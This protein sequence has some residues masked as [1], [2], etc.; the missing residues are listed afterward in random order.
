M[1]DKKDD[2]TKPAETPKDATPAEVVADDVVEL[3]EG[4]RILL[5][6]LRDMPDHKLTKAER[7]QG[8]V[9]KQWHGID[10]YQC[11]FCPADNMEEWI[12]RQ[13]VIDQ[14][15]TP[16]SAPSV[17]MSV[18]VYDRHGNLITERRV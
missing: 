11:I 10:V 15:I 6:G 1:T 14:H 16:A 4:Q 5:L 13:H 12:L 3:D 9:V 18:P 7:E 8:Y 17:P 2:Q